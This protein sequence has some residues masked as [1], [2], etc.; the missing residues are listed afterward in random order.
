MAKDSG[1]PRQS[2]VEGITYSY[3]PDSLRLD[4][5]QIDA[6]CKLSASHAVG[7]LV[8]LEANPDEFPGQGA[9]CVES[10]LPDAD[11][12]IALGEIIYEGYGEFIESMLSDNR[13][14]GRLRDIGGRLE[15]GKNVAHSIFHGPLLDDGLAH[16]AMTIGLKVL[17]YD[18]N[19]AMIVSGGTA[20]LGLKLKGEGIPEG[21]RLPITSGLN[22]GC[23]KVWH[24]IP[25]T[26]NARE[27]DFARFVSEEQI[28]GLN[29]LTIG[30]LESDLGDG[31]WLFTVLPDG[32][33]HKRGSDGEYVLFNPGRRTLEVMSYPGTYVQAAGG[34]FRDRQEPLYDFFGGPRRFSRFER[35]R[36]LQGDAM[37][38]DMAA[39]ASELIPDE[40]FRVEPPRRLGSFAVGRLRQVG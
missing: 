31:G 32:S 17:R 16:G 1:P 15:A 24:T 21:T 20:G 35:F 4:D 3:P 18:F 5:E 33:T 6:L 12:M 11:T 10:P 28:K 29:D 2:T 39:G 38:L 8:Q 13:M 30:G 26:D 34:R 27:S 25:R 23:D 37:M 22:T 40:E 14:L 19:A 9:Y 36:L 7:D